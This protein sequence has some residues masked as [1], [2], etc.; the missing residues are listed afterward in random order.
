MYLWIVDDEDEYGKYLETSLELRKYEKEYF[1]SQAE[2]AHSFR[3]YMLDRDVS[4]PI[5]SV[6]VSIRSIVAVN[7]IVEVIV[8]VV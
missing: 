1:K 7:A 4:K 5:M 8:S 2:F 3:S 6:V